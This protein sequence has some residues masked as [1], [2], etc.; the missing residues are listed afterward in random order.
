MSG[1]RRVL[2]LTLV[3]VAVLTMATNVWAATGTIQVTVY[4]K[5]KEGQ[6][7]LPGAV[8]T[9]S[10]PKKSFPDQAKPA[11]IDGKVTFENVPAGSGYL[12]TAANAGY[13]SGTQTD[14]RVAAGQTA[15]IKLQ[16]VAN[17]A[18]AETKEVTAKGKVVEIER[19]ESDTTI[20]K[21]LF[22]DLPIYGR[23]Y[24]AALTLAPGIQDSDGDGAPTIH[25]SRE[26]DLKTTVDGASNVNPLTG[27][28]LAGVNPDAIEE[29]EIIDSGADASSGGA[30]GGF[31]KITLKSG[32]NS[33]EGSTEIRFRDSAFDHDGVGGDPQP[34]KFFEP[35]LYVSGPVIKDHLWYVV[36]AD[37]IDQSVPIKVIGGETPVQVYKE[38]KVQSKLTWQVNPS[39]RMSFQFQTDPYRVKPVGVDAVTPSD[40]AVDVKRTGPA[41]LLDWQATLSPTASWTSRASVTRLEDNSRP[42]RP[43]A[44]NHCV[45]AAPYHDYYCTDDNNGGLVSGAYPIT[46]KALIDVWGYA[47]DGTKFVADWLGGQHTVSYGLEL[48]RTRFARDLKFEPTL[49]FSDVVYPPGAALGGGQ[50]FP[51]QVLQLTQAFPLKDE[52]QVKGNNIAFYATDAFRPSSSLFL[53][54]GFRYNR[55]EVSTDGWAPFDA[56]RER[57]RYSA[58]NRE[59]IAAGFPP[60]VCV[61]NNS[62]LLTA[63]PE[64]DPRRYPACNAPNVPNDIQCTFLQRA[65][66]AGFPVHFRERD[67]HTLV[68]SN[69]SPRLSLAWDPWN[70]GKTQVLG[71]YGLYYGDTFFLPYLNEQGPNRLSKRLLVRNT[72][73]A[74]SI[75]AQTGAAFS[76][77]TVDRAIRSQYNAEYA[78][79]ITRD[80]GNETALK[81]RYVNRKY[82][83][84][85]QDTDINHRP[86]LASELTPR[87]LARFTQCFRIGKFADCTGDKIGVEIRDGF[88]NTKIIEAEVPDGQPDLQVISPFFNNIYKVSNFNSSRYQAYVLEIDRRFYQ[89]WEANASYTWSNSLGQAEDYNDEAGNDL[90]NA[91]DE[92][93]PLS[94]DQ[95]H[96]LKLV[97]RVLVPRWGGFRLGGNFVYQSGL[98]YSVVRLKDVLDFPTDL[99]GVGNGNTIVYTTRRTTFPTGQRNDHRNAP[100]W[101]FDVN[102]QKEF[103]VKDFKVT[104][105][106]GMYN[107]LNSQTTFITE[108]RQQETRR[109]DGSRRFTERPIAFTSFGRYF[110]L[111]LKMNF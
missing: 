71:S 78:L 25:G 10:D 19:T 77:R 83:D 29:I 85:L 106:A 70:D 68:N 104:F 45:T 52:F 105:L 97:G 40:S 72:G 109:E 50:Q 5:T 12:L 111:S 55:E 62:Y 28:Q 17:D 23:D 4:E 53:R 93:G 37:H 39:N 43:G 46:R 38:F 103:T 3:W 9:L 36:T 94:T 66:D 108:V 6:D 30:V 87:D 24:Q 110:E 44:K 80:L 88:G 35:S 64:D 33:F 41:F 22:T 57:A 107:L 99:S 82:R 101:N 96:V 27:Q 8:V 32:G 69:I 89:N 60:A 75:D 13:Q 79:G 11:D 54:I 67:N 31:A 14:V 91:D 61:F 34:F 18:F 7:T 20:G 47:L 100:W 81:I 73:G 92:V 49:A 1:Q 95:R 16:L 48:N 86:V 21:D 42:F 58:A 74:P 98:P 63:A 26:R 84:L 59:C 2:A 76:I 102:F 65:V 56:E 15:V 51:T 90:T